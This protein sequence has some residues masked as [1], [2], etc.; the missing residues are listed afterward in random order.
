MAALSENN[1]TPPPEVREFNY[2]I[3]RD[4]VSRFR[5]F[6]HPDHKKKNDA[7]LAKRLND[8][9]AKA[10]E[11]NNHTKVVDA[12][13]PSVDTIVAEIEERNQRCWVVLRIHKPN[14]YP[15]INTVAGPAG[16]ALAAITVLTSE[17]GGENFAS[18][19]WAVPEHKEPM[20][21]SPFAAGAN[22][23]KLRAVTVSRQQAP[24][25]R[26]VVPIQ[27]EEK[28]RRP[29]GGSRPEGS[30]SHEQRERRLQ[31]MRDELRKRPFM[32]FS[33]ADGMKPLLI[34]T[35]GIAVE[36]GTF[37]EIRAQ[38]QAELQRATGHAPLPPRT[39]GYGAVSKMEVSA[40]QLGPS[41]HPVSLP[42]ETTI[43]T[44]RP[45]P[46]ADVLAMGMEFAQAM[47]DERTA[48]EKV[49]SAEEALERA[50]AELKAARE[51]RQAIFSKMS[52]PQ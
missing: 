19:A 1:W 12:K 25:P 14:A 22:A 28:P 36:L 43:V 42:G 15:Y 49:R 31:F 9:I 21:N 2:H 33:G 8:L 32:N 27:P 11:R 45:S 37:N 46:A 38:V 41:G 7:L 29:G 48:K 44:T 3:T 35:F 5:D 6:V 10:F 47:Q 40:Q 24:P 52:E 50:N 39:G 13:F 20:A 18:G 26:V 16:S 23:A 34:K 30:M 17:R 4:A 51:A